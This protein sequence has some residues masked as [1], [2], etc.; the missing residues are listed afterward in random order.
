MIE[1]NV[2][3]PDSDPAEIEG[4]TIVVDVLRAFSVAYFIQANHPICPLSDLCSKR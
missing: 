1:V 3:S 2:Y 4:F